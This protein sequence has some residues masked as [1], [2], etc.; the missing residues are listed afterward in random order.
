[1]YSSMLGLEALDVGGRDVVE[2]ARVPAK[3][4]TTCSSTGIGL[5]SGCFS[6]S[7]SR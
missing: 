5:L 6:S 1:M 7:T 4:E 2:V 3:I